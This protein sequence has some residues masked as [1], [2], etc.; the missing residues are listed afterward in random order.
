MK[1]LLHRRTVLACTLFAAL[2]SPF[3]ALA[4]ATYPSRP[5]TWIVAYPAGG[6]SDFL[7]RTVAT[8]LGKQLGQSVLIDNRPGA[9]TIVGAQA[10]AR[11]AGDGY[12]LF[13]ADNGSMVFNPALYSKLPYKA[14]DFAPIGL[15]ANFPLI[16]VTSPTSG[17]ATAKSVIDAAKAD[18]KKIN[19]ASPGAGSPHHLAMELLQAR[20]GFG[21][22]H[23]AYK[24]GA[25]AVQDLMGGQVQVMMLDGPGA[26]PLL[27]GGKLRG[28]A[29]ASA[30]R[31]P[32]F[33]DI[34]TLK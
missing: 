3:G 23:I 30:R 8:Q 11:A 4:Q 9:A 18:P 21:A 14:S 20:G 26:T 15:M 16:M 29:V 6:G 5:I 7:A 17:Y 32:T 12:T 2:A 13:T 33:P 34:P 24:G 10:A 22:E 28:L 25:P 27:R 31:L 19:F 1:H